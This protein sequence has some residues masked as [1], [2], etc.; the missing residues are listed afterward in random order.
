MNRP[1]G[2][3]LLTLNRAAIVARLLAGV[4]HE[5]NNALLVISGTAELLEDRT[6]SP[7]AIG[8]GLERI[9]FQTT[10][11][12]GAIAEV[13]SFA[14]AAPGTHGPVN[15]RQVT[16]SAVD[17]R[18][19]AIGRAGLQVS[20]SA[21]DDV[22]FIVEGSRV[23]LQQAVLNLIANAEQALA[24][25]RGGKMSL[26]LAEREGSAVLR[27]SDTGPGI[28]GEERERIFEPFVTTRAREEFTGLGLPA[29]RRIAEAH[30]G[31]LALAAA[32]ATGSTFVLT[33]PLSRRPR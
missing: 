24:G 2:D 28:P 26:V 7:E 25:T 1:D 15:L 17:L 5:V 13:L 23:L 3:D 22:S 27:V 30:G 21:P 6:G 14:R 33:L 32:D 4:A 18:S 9:R 10:R 19:Y 8:R 31:S 12:A 29:T 20:I 11:A 16:A